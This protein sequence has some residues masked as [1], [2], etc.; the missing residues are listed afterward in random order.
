VGHLEPSMRWKWGDSVPGLRGGSRLGVA[1]AGFPSNPRT[2]SAPKLLEWIACGMDQGRSDDSEGT[3]VLVAAGVARH[4]RGH[5]NLDSVEGL[6][7]PDEAGHRRP[8]WITV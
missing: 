2:L 3:S 4:A 5:F 6:D 7:A 1:S 8:L